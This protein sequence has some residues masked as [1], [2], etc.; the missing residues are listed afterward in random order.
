MFKTP[1]QFSHSNIPHLI[2]PK[3][4]DNCRAPIKNDPGLYDSV[5][6]TLMHRR[7][8]PTIAS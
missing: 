7:F 2:R 8:S 6:Q 5:Y 3:T 1:R 4:A